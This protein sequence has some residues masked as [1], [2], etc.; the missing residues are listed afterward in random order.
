MSYSLGDAHME[1]W[2]EEK[3]RMWSMAED[4]RKHLCE[5]NP[6]DKFAQAVYH[7]YLVARLQYF[8]S[9]ENTDELSDEEWD[10]YHWFEREMERFTNDGKFEYQCEP[11]HEEYG[12]DF[13]EDLNSLSSDVDKEGLLQEISLFEQKSV[14]DYHDDN[15]GTRHVIQSSIHNGRFQEI[16]TQ[17]IHCDF[18]PEI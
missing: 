17:C 6:Y 14:A 1:Q 10:D 3:D 16:I 4:A 18:Q 9:K 12:V 5:I 11:P 8:E 13:D 2:Q 7:F 15:G